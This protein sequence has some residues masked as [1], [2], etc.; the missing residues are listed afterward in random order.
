V[1]V[2]Q[3]IIDMVGGTA[4]G[5][6]TDSISMLPY[7]RDTAQD[8][9]FTDW[10]ARAYT[11]GQFFVPS[12]MPPLAGRSQHGGECATISDGTYKL[13]YQNGTYTLSELV[14]DPATQS[15]VESA[16]NDLQHAKARELWQ[17]LT[18]P[19]SP[20]YAQV[21]STGHTFPPLTA[22]GVPNFPVKIVGIDKNAEVVTLQN[23]SSEAVNLD[24]WTMISMAG[25]QYH[26]GIGGT[27]APGE[28]RDFPHI[29]RAIWA[30]TASDPGELR[31]AQERVVSYWDD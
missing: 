25:G 1:D 21:N 22:S 15:F 12:D 2:F 29:G 9:R 26:R 5:Y 13:T 23:V 6:P 14:L 17:A 11:F 7:L 19:G 27:L 10:Q 4:P 20:Q 28:T 18:T 8:A 16:I 24:G 3:T 30:N 31:D